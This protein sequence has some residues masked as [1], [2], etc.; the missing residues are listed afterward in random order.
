MSPSA[1]K[2]HLKPVLFHNVVEIYALCVTSAEV[3]PGPP[4]GQYGWLVGCLEEM[5]TDLSYIGP[6]ASCRKGLLQG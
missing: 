4:T 1:F 3:P 2:I 6:T 5:G